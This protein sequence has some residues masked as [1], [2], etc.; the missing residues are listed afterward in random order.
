MPFIKKNKI[1]NIVYVSITIF[2]EHGF[3]FT[4]ISVLE[5]YV[6]TYICIY[7]LAYKDIE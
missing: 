2:I 1:D 6:D 3:E 5:M 7:V 4:C